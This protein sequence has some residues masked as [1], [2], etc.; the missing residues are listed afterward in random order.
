MRASFLSCF[1]ASV[2]SALSGLIFPYIDNNHSLFWRS[3]LLIVCEMRSTTTV[4]L[5][6]KVRHSICLPLSKLHRKFYS[7][8]VCQ[9]NRYSNMSPHSFSTQPH[10]DHTQF[11]L[12]HVH[13]PTHTQFVQNNS[14]HV[15]T[16]FAVSNYVWPSK[17]SLSSI[18]SDVYSEIVH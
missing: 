12:A 11:V 15:L 10:P 4:S 2:K 17:N 1:E 6:L 5:R 18:Y 14:K 9:H 7:Q 16:S 13:N 3:M 8:I